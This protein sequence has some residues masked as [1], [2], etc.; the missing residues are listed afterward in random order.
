MLILH[1]KLT[2]HIGVKHM[3]TVVVQIPATLEWTKVFEA[4]RDRGEFDIETDGATTVDLIVDSEGEQIIKDAG[5]RKQGKPADGGTRYKI[6]RP[7][8]DKFDREWA[9]GPPDV[10][11]PDGSK[12]DIDT[13]GMIGNGSTGIVFVEV[14]DTKMGKGCRLKG[15]Q[16]INHVPYGDTGG[17]SN[18]I[19]PKNYTDAAPA[20]TPPAATAAAS[21]TSV[22]DIPF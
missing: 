21:D 2:N 20:A 1:Y 5:I 4:T 7:W 11:A 6:K 14:Y 3:A 8:K 9:A 17:G 18:S 12:W 19:K 16:V 13:N 15:L 22:G 10:Y